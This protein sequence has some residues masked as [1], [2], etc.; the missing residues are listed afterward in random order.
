MAGTVKRTRLRTILIGGAAALIVGAATVILFASGTSDAPFAFLADR[1]PVARYPFDAASGGVPIPETA[2]YSF[3]GDYD[4]LAKAMAEE[5]KTF[6]FESNI[7]EETAQFYMRSSSIVY[8]GRGAYVFRG[9]GRPA[10]AAIAKHQSV[11]IWKD[12][13]YDPKSLGQRRSL[14]FGDIQPGW[15]TIQLF[16]QHGRNDLLQRI[17]SWFG[18]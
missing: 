15:V 9:V 8:L 1:K 6:G 7:G 2:V 5:L 10:R 11:L 18:L 3:K 14:G 13:R 17:R 4:V 16:G 12:V